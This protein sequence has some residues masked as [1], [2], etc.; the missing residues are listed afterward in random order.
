MADINELAR[1]LGITLTPSVSVEYLSSFTE[2]EPEDEEPATPTHP[3]P[4]VDIDGFFELV[5]NVVIYAQEQTNVAPEYFLDYSD[6]YPDAGMYNN[7]DKGIDKYSDG[8]VYRLEERIPGSMSTRRATNGGDG[9]NY[10]P[11]IREDNIKVDNYPGYTF[12][13]K[14][15]FFENVVTFDIYSTKAIIANRRARWFENVMLDYAWYFKL[16][17]VECIFQRQGPDRTDANFKQPFKI[18]PMTYW[19]RTEKLFHSLDKTLDIV[20]IK[21][22]PTDTIETTVLGNEITMLRLKK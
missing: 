9:V 4:V 13:I 17:G 5:R 20:N 15:M 1:D 11:R 2:Y 18:R 12:T 21:I 22:K 7:E 3:L 8:I 10:K 6:S 19:V 16:H 14:G